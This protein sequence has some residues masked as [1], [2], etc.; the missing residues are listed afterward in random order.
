[1][2]KFLVASQGNKLVIMNP[3][4]FPISNQEALEL[5]AWI[6]ACTPFGM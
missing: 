4:R 5:A 2:N 3:P 1:M 6:L